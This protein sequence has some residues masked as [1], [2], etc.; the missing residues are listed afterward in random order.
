LENTDEKPISQGKLLV[1]L[2]AFN[3][4][5][6]IVWFLGIALCLYVGVALPIRYGGGQTTTINLVYKLILD[7]KMHVIIPY[8][9]ATL[10]FGLWK[11]ERRLRKISVK[12]EHERVDA[13]ERRL[14]PYRSSSGLKE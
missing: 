2:Q 5:R 12:R 8:A 9:V 14:D 13:L 3:L 4:L 11:R 1:I 6:L 10:L 7:L